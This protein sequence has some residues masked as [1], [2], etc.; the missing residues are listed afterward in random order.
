MNEPAVS[1]LL[2][3]YNAS[4][5]LPEALASLCAQEF[6]NWELVA[7]DDGSSDDTAAL[8][9]NA[10][11][12]DQ[13]I[14]PL[15][16]PHQGLVPALNS[17]LAACQAPLVA[18][19]DAD[20]RMHPARL[21]LQVEYMQAHPETDLV[22]ALVECFP[23]E[24]IHEG[25]ALYQEWQNS[26]LTHAAIVRDLFVESPFVHPSVT[27]RREQVCRLGGYQDNGWAEDYDL[28]LRL[29]QDGARFAK[30]PVVLHYWRDR[31]ERMT[32]ACEAYSL[33]NFRRLKIH[34]LQRGFLRDQVCIWGAGRGGKVWGAELEAA[35]IA[36]RYYVDID[37]KKIGHVR[38]GRPVIAPADLPEPGGDPMLVAVGFKGARELIRAELDSRGF[39]EG[40]DYRCVA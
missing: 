11:A 23:R 15:F 25:L 19:M 14:R 27:F 20:D 31:E 6:E 4:L 33:H 2:P 22:G 1:V 17:G 34:Y 8:L 39:V 26:L 13:R 32:R 18:R 10:A 16:L 37:P 35:G 40:R 12:T 28:W 24:Q 36:I 30:V 29:W 5:Y 3:A 9:R 7:V 38:R 21:R